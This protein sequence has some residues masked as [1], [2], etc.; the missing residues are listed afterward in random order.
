MKKLS[1]IL[2]A[3]F[4][5][6]FTAFS[7][8]DNKV[9]TWKFSVK[10]LGGENYQLNAEAVLKEGFH[11][12]AMDAGGDGSLINTEI[13]IDSSAIKWLDPV[14]ESSNKPKTE[15]YD[16]IEGAVH[17]FE[18]KVTLSRKFKSAV[19]PK[20]KGIVTF[21]TCNESMCFPPEDVPFEIK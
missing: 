18:K 1:F 15:T 8:D 2:I 17:Y 14:W 4:S 3:I 16:F 7:K 19:A 5:L 20:I 6:V 21:Q 13:V 11:I 12:W 10:A 9:V